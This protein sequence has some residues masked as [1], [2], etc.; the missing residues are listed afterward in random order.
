L[1]QTSVAPPPL[2]AAR[3]PTFPRRVT[4]P[5]ALEET[6]S[7][8]AA[9]AP[10]DAGNRQVEIAATA[11]DRAAFRQSRAIRVEAPK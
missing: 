2:F 3:E 9:P 7:D 10:L 8:D 1:S 4:G 11:A 6:S 5:L